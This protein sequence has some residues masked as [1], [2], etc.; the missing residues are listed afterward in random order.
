MTTY[1]SLFSGV[2]GFD[3]GFDNA[4][5]DCRWQVEWDK[6]CQQTLAYHWPDVPKHGDV[7]DVSG[8]DLEPVDVIIYGSPCQDLSVAGRRAGLDGTKSSMF[9]ESVRIFKEMR[10]AT[11]GIFPRIVVW[12]NVPG[13]L[14]SNRGNDFGAVL[15]A[16]DDIGALG[17]WWNVLDAQYFGVPQRRRRVFLISV[18]DPAIIGRTGTQQILSVG[19]GR[20]RNT[21]KSRQ[22][23]EI[24]ASLTATGVGTC[25]ADDNQA[26]AGHIIAPDVAQ[27]LC[28]SGN[29][30][31]F[32]T[33]PG[34]HIIAFAHTQSFDIQPSEIHTPTLRGGGDGAAVALVHDPGTIG[35][36][37]SSGMSRAR[38]TESIDS[39]HV[40]A[41]HPHYHD[42]A[43]PQGDVI[44]TI[45]SRWGTGGNNG[46]MI[47][48]NFDEYNFTG[49]NDIH[50]Q[51]RAGTRQS[52][53]VLQN[54]IVR[55]LT[56]IECERLMGW[57]DNHTLH[58]ADGKTNSDSTRYKMCGNGVATPVAQWI[59]QQL[60][61]IL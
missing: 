22:E 46:T 9:F 56:P 10:N 48:T 30:G 32:R 51:I 61:G 58:R 31:G 2:G 25:G 20:R 59:A 54:A 21:S 27:T 29:T 60:K 5:Y 28:S 42:G 16:L 17:Q 14:N 8:Y 37:T 36:L 52:T 43:R 1:G 40:I 47:A 4:G 18:F 6:H 38:G 13:A 35:P 44:N 39:S 50:H 55:R 53:G 15:T 49:G 23:R 7:Q 26:Q 45:T 33:E 34:D 41:F 11:A 57:P 12:E 19:K 3:M 24:V